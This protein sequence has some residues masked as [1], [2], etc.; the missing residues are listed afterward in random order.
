MRTNYTVIDQNTWARKE[1]FEHYLKNVPCTYSLTTQLDITPIRRRRLKLY[2]AMLWCLT[3]VVNRHPAFRMALNERHELLLY[4]AMEPCYTV[5][6]K[7]T[8]TFSNLWTPFCED[9][10]AF[11]RRY[12]DDVARYGKVEKFFAK[13]D[14]PPNCFTVSMIP[15]T[16]F[17][18]FN[19]N[20][21]NFRYLIPIFTM[22]RFA[23]QK[24]RVLLPI[25]V[26]VHHAVCD[27]W[28]LSRFLEDLQSEVEALGLA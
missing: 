18:G 25:A 5:F 22:G 4:D 13:P 26:Q 15:W 2:P 8:E 27:G 3:A 11:C 19:L 17:D 7:E 10:A 1:T 9:F 14:L 21:A 20:V 24:G 28:H 12:E 23:E 6:H 16:S